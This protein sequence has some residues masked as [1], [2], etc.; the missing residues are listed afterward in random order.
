[1]KISEEVDATTVNALLD[2]LALLLVL[3]ECGPEW[4]LE[5]G[6]V[7]DSHHF[8]DVDRGFAGVV[9]RDSA[10][11]MVADV[12]ANDIMEKVSVDEAKITIDG[13]CCTACKCP[14]RVA[15]M[16]ELSICVLKECNGH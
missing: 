4:R 8:L 16:W 6:F 2:E 7:V 13:R 10:D 9:K 11:E 1:M 14:G 3:P 15:V 5:I 12:C